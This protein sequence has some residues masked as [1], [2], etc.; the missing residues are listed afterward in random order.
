MQNDPLVDP[1]V[2]VETQ[3]FAGIAVAVGRAGNGR[4]KRL[5]F[6][7]GWRWS[8]DA[9]P[10]INT[11]HCK[12]VHVGFLAR[13]KLSGE[14]ADGDSFS[15]VAPAIVSIAPGHDLWV[16]GDQQAVLIQFDFERETADR[17]G[18]RSR[19]QTF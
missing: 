5:S 9:K 15:Y 17:F 19:S 11:E 8:T 7:T 3:S 6:P 2:D 18:L 10:L 14:Y 1:I 12:H 4:V 16:E 13:G